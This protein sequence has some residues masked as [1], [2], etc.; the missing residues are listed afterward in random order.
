MKIQLTDFQ[1]KEMQD[2]LQT[3]HFEFFGSRMQQNN[4]ALPA[5]NRL[6]KLAAP[7]KIIEIGAGDCGLSLFFAM[8]C[9]IK[10]KKFHTFDIANRNPSQEQLLS[11]FNT[12]LEIIDCLEDT[13]GVEYVKSI[14]ESPG[15]N[16]IVCDAGKALEFNLYSPFVKSGDVLICHDHAA[17][18]EIFN[19]EVKGIFWNWFES[20]DDRVKESCE[21]YKLIKIMESDLSPAVWGAWV[22]E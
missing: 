3:T 22:K 14:I 5:L 21:K 18:P 12:K 20:W 7:D 10:N 11:K 19:S 8:Y 4:L 2:T 17:T 1:K 9:Y 6:I 16:L 15:S 13:K